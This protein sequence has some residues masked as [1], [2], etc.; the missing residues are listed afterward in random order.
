MAIDGKDFWIAESVKTVIDANGE[1]TLQFNGTYGVSWNNVGTFA[2]ENANALKGTVADTYTDG[3]WATSGGDI[4]HVGPTVSKHINKELLFISTERLEGVAQITDWRNNWYKPASG[5]FQVY[6]ENYTTLNNTRFALQPERVIFDATPYD[7]FNNFAAPGDEITTN[8]AGLPNAFASNQQYAIEWTDSKGNVVVSATPAFVATDGTIPSVPMTVP[9]DLVGTKTYTAKLYAY[10]TNGNR[11]AVP[12][13]V[14]SFTATSTRQNLNF[15][16]EYATELVTPGTP[17]TSTPII[18]DNDGAE[19]TAPEGTQFAIPE[20]YVAPD[21]YTVFIDPTTGVVTVTALDSPT[22]LTVES[23]EVPVVVTYPDGS[24]DE[25]VAPFQLDTDG[26]NTPDMTDTDDDGD[27][28]DDS[29]E[30]ED[31]TN[32]KDPNSVAS[33]IENIDDQTG[34]VGEEITPITVVT[35]KIPTN[36]SV[37][38][39]GLPDSVTYNPETGEIT[40]KPTTE[41]TYEVTVTV[42][43]KDGNPVT[44]PDGNPVTETFTFTVMPKPT[45]AET[46][47]PVGQDVTVPVGEQPN[48]N[49]TVS[50]L[51]ELPVGTT[52]D[53][54]EPV[55]TSTVGDKEVVVVVT[56]PDG[57]TDEVT[58]TVTVIDTIAPEAPVISDKDGNIIVTPAKDATELIITYVDE[59]GKTQTVVVI[60][61]SNGQWVTDNTVVTVNPETG[62]VTIP[63]EAVKADTELTAVNFDEAGNE[64]DTSVATIGNADEEVISPDKETGNVVKEIMK[65][66][67]F[68]V[69]N[70]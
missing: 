25:T 40:G 55:D 59:N 67:H 29:T 69:Q 50:N 42:L 12:L 44:G 4:S 19:T 47:E 10:D 23:F 65:R 18:T 41:G 28:V 38:V 56:Y 3:R 66:Q 63:G 33:T 60:K 15:E 37:D 70:L 35:D 1:Y 11:S 32:T 51:P 49:D 9:A 62:E 48:A 43:D 6:T 57:T 64:S 21:G 5:N 22:L 68:S 53:F 31:G 52:V 58:V 27:G 46:N 2:D 34:T 45:D 54:K 39:K 30:K 16:P 36:G 13:A 8:T 14:D 24:V 20:G 17:A 61:D 26:D 7:S